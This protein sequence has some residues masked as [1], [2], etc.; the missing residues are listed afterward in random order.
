M[1]KRFYLKEFI[2][3]LLFALSIGLS[4]LC[5][6]KSIIIQQEQNVFYEEVGNLNYKICLKI[7]FHFH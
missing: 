3:I 6:K 2:L 1:K 4:F 5:F 7:L